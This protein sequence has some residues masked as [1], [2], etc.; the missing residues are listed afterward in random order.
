MQEYG[1]MCGC[2]GPNTSAVLLLHHILQRLLK[3]TSCQSELQRKLCGERY[4]KLKTRRSLIFDR[5]RAD[6]QVTAQGNSRS[7]TAFETSSQQTTLWLVIH[8]PFLFFPSSYQFLFTNPSLPSSHGIHTKLFPPPYGRVVTATDPTE[9]FE[10]WN[11]SNETV[12]WSCQWQHVYCVWDQS[13][14]NSTSE[15]QKV[16]ERVKHDRTSSHNQVK[17]L[18]TLE[19]KS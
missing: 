3:C 10:Y 15:R 18:Y 7:S 13:N 11:C 1:C 12:L 17:A 8:L 5:K 19:Y 14:W 9:A 4:W 6:S 2:F 16:T